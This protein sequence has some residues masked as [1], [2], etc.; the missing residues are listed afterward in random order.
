MTLKLPVLGD[1]TQTAMITEWL[2]AVGDT[3]TKGQPLVSV[4]ADKAVVEVPS[5][6]NGVIRELLAALED[7][8]DI[9]DPLVVIDTVDI[10]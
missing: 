5:P 3:V 2:V 6:V 4:E 7:E 1:T 9:G 10:T 8:L